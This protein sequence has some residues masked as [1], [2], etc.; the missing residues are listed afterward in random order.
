MA[1]VLL[2]A[3]IIENDEAFV[4]ALF[5][6]I[7]IFCCRKLYLLPSIFALYEGVINANVDLFY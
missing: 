6:C 4:K 7:F 2:H 1:N 5:L 3:R